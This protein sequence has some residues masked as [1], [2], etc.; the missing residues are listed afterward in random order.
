MNNLKGRLSRLENARGRDPDETFEIAGLVMTHRELTETMDWVGKFGRRIGETNQ[1]YEER[2]QD[3]VQ[4][5]VVSAPM[6]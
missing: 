4:Y 6:T 2:L 5:A 3:R 1:D